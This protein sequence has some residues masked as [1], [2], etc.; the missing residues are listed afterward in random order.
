MRSN[1]LWVVLSV[2]AV[3]LAMAASLVVSIGEDVVTIYSAT[4]GATTAAASAA[5]AAS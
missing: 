3:A 4:G 2:A 1:R 5:G